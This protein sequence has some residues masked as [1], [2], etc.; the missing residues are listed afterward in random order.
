MQY[1][2]III[3]KYGNN[4]IIINRTQKYNYLSTTTKNEMTHSGCKNDKTKE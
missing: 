4:L 1:N 2:S 3:I